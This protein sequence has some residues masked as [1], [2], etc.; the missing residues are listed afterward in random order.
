MNN[1]KDISRGGSRIYKYEAK[2]DQEFRMPITYGLF[3]K[4]IEN[5]FNELFPG[6]E[7]SVFHEILSELVHLDV[8]I[9]YPTEKTPFYIVYTTGMSDLA[10]TLPDDLKEQKDLE[11]AELFLFLPDSWNP[12]EIGQIS[13][14]LTYEQYWPIQMIKYLARF[15]HDYET[16]LGWGHTIP[17]G[18]DYE[19]LVDGSEMGG[20]ILMELDE[21][22]SPL[23]TEDQTE[24]H[25]YMATP[26][27]REEIEYKLEHGMSALSELF[28]QN[29][30]PLV[31]D[32]NRRNYCR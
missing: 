18:A 22:M 30:L 1:P 9:M 21:Q 15:P 31:I 5:H 27:Y 19:P 14:D 4:E 25:L 28:A 29:D 8:H 11:R 6:R 12:G 13:S 20:I 7:T 24:I 17:N 26:A 3:A 23:R 2:E 32:M 10:M 16:W